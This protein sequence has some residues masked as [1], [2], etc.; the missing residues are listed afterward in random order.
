MRRF[1]LGF[2]FCILANSS[3]AQS[4]PS[5]WP[6]PQCGSGNLGER[7][8]VSKYLRFYPTK[9]TAERNVLLPLQDLSDLGPTKDFHDIL[10]GLQPESE[11][12]SYEVIVYTDQNIDKPQGAVSVIVP[13]WFPTK[14]VDLADFKLRDVSG[15]LPKLFQI[16][17]PNTP[18]AT[19][20]GGMLKGAI[21]HPCIPIIGLESNGHTL[22]YVQGWVWRGSEPLANFLSPI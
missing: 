5:T 21:N 11:R 1:L 9:A 22:A 14:K 15:V 16:A 3:F 19:A 17:D 4:T 6:P 13:L 8:V 18:G 20:A 12:D 2:I 10:A 7:Y